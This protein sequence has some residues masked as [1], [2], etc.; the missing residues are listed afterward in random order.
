MGFCLSP[1][2]CRITLQI[3]YVNR[4]FSFF[5]IKCRSIE[6]WKIIEKYM[7]DLWKYALE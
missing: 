7:K 1:N 6:F 3:L 2:M 5:T 4:G